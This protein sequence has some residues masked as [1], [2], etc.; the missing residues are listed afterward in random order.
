[1]SENEFDYNRRRFLAATGLLGASAGLAGCGGPSTVET[2][3]SP[4]GGTTETE[5]NNTT[6]T[7]DM[8]G[9]TFIGTTT[10]NAPTL[11]P[12]MNELAWYNSFS[13]YLFDTLYAVSPDGSEIVPHLASDLPQD[14]GDA[15]FDVPLKETVSFHDGENLTAEDVAYT[16]NWILDPDNG[17]P[18][19]ANLNFVNEVTVQD[20]YTARFDL[21]FPFALFRQVLSTANA[22]IVPQHAAEGN[23]DAFAEEPVG[24]GPFQFETFESADRIELSRFSDY[25][26]KEPN[27]DGVNWRVIPERQVQFVELA[28]GGVDQASVPQTL[29]EKA[30]NED[31]INVKVVPQLDYNGLIFNSTREPFDKLKAR[32]AMQYLVDYDAMLEATKG[33]LGDRS[34]GFLPPQVNEAWDF[35]A[36]E[37]R[38]KYYPD[39]DVDRARE[40]LDEAGY[41]N[42]DKTL[43][44]SSLASAE[45]KNMTII[46][47]E[48]LQKVGIE[49]EV[50]EVTIGQWLDDLTTKEYD[51][52]IY[53][54]AGGQDPD[55][56]YYF[57]FRDE[58]NDSD[59]NADEWNGDASAGLLY[60]LNQETG[61]YG[62]KL[63]T[64]DSNIR[65]ARRLQSKEERRPLYIEAADALQSLYPHIPV[66]SEGS[67]L[68]WNANVQDY[69]PTAFLEQPLCSNWSNAFI[70]EG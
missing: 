11:D 12:R 6:A 32:R 35:P 47:Q 14:Q 48:Q 67:A 70:D 29:L 46:F 69:N 36:D 41:L 40:L 66:Y 22:A 7:E 44:M 60:K 62:D 45:F 24:S 58:R 38:E 20:T 30:R 8:Q 63:E 61:K 4:A 3:E 43:K 21:N 23:Q 26:L 10:E 33:P 34:I 17:S 51:V 53:G 57:L 64:I 54:W 59:Y 19:R 37:W 68:A 15:V 9:G 56:F 31:G 16:I 52:T 18:N 5:M 49:S 1:M 25:F 2:T 55:G 65:E 39:Q 13:H 50:E 42:M 28:T 27:L